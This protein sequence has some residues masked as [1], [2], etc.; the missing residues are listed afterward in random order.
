MGSPQLSPNALITH[1]LDDLVDTRTAAEQCH[2]EPATVRKWKSRGLI[3]P[4]GL[5]SYGNP[6][7][8][9]IDVLR[10]EQKTRHRGQNRR[11]MA[12]TS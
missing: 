5:D 3:E 11:K 6:M 7:Y 1:D 4:S 12:A 10:A 9:L 8:R 2:V